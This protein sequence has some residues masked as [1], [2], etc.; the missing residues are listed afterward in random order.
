MGQFWWS[1]S[2]QCDYIWYIQY[3]IYIQYWT[4]HIQMVKV[5]CV[6]WFLTKKEKITI[7]TE[8][9][10]KQNKRNHHS[11]LHKGK[12]KVLWQLIPF[13]SNGNIKTWGLSVWTAQLV[14][15][16]CSKQSSIITDHQLQ[17]QEEKV[18]RSSPLQP[19]S[20]PLLVPSSCPGSSMPSVMPS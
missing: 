14:S 19:S 7:S 13:V 20:L 2:K 12:Q 6:M 11:Y 15:V 18:Q 16:L 4:E 17:W 5:I 3:N 1:V 10:T 8:E 9:K